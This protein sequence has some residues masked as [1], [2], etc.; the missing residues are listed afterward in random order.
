MKASGAVLLVA[1]LATVPEPGT[2]Q[3]FPSQAPGVR[4]GTWFG[5]GAGLG[6][7]SLSCRICASDRRTGTSVSLRGGLTLNPRVKLG[8]ELGGWARFDEVDQLLGTLTSAAYFYPNAAG[9][10]YVKAGPS[11][12]FFSA[13][14]S[15][16]TE[17]GATSYGLLLGAGYE[18]GIG[19]ETLLVPYLDLAAT[20]FG[21][22]TSDGRE[23]T[24]GAGVTLVHLGV[25]LV[26]P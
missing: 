22:L 5:L 10:W 2:A 13:R 23:I 6:S 16:G 15:E 12:S 1:A 11:L 26:F 3:P 14:D 8:L 18:I 24:G 25:G 21:S 4:S 19:G 17:V 20:S 7:S 9:G